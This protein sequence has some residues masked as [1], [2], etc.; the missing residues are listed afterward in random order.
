MPKKMKE[1]ISQALDSAKGAQ[2]TIEEEREV[3]REDISPQLYTELENEWYRNF[4]VM[5]LFVLPEEQNNLLQYAVLGLLIV[6]I[7]V[8]FI[9]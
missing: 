7:I 9:R 5:R 1:I 8:S 4:N 6:N 2:Q 3:T